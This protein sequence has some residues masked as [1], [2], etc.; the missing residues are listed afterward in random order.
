MDPTTPTNTA[1]D[2]SGLTP[3]LNEQQIRENINALQKG[4]LTNDKVQSYVDNYS[5]GL[6]GNYV[7]KSSNAGKD[8]QSGK[9]TGAF[10][11]ADTTS[12]SINGVD[13]LKMI[14][15]IVSSA[16]KPVKD[17][18]NTVSQYPEQIQGLIKES[19]GLGNAIQNFASASLDT[20]LKSL[21]NI[22]VGILEHI[23]TQFGGKE[24]S[25]GDLPGVARTI[26]RNLINDPVGMFLSM[27]GIKGSLEGGTEAI[28]TGDLSK[29]ME[30]GR[31]G[32]NKPMEL[33]TPAIPEAVKNIVGQTADKAGGIAND[34]ANSLE[35]I[36]LRLTPVQKVNLGSKL[37]DITDF[38]LKNDITG[39][40]E[41][42]YEKITELYNQKENTLQKFLN[43]DAKNVTVPKEQ[44]L[45]DLESLKG[46]YQDER[47]VLAIEKQID[48]LKNTIELKYPKDI[49][50]SKLNNLKRS[51]F[52]NAYN[53]AGDKVVDFVEH[54]MGDVLYS[55]VKDALKE[56][57]IGPEGKS[58]EDF[59]KEYGNIITS[60]KLLKIAQS[61]PEIGL[62]GKL[63][64]R[65]IG[66]LV[67][68]VFGGGPIGSAT[69]MIAGPTAAEA[70]AGTASRSTVA[71]TLKNI[72]ETIK[73]LN[74]EAPTA[75]PSGIGESPTLGNTKTLPD[76]TI[77]PPNPS[78]F[79]QGGI[80]QTNIVYHGTKAPIDSLKQ[81]DVLQYGKP[82]ALYGPGLY[83]TDNPEVAK[84]Y[85]ITKGHGEVG[86]VLSG[87]IKSNVKLLN[88]DENLN[89]E[90]LK[91][92]EHG[93]N[94]GN[95]SGIP[96]QLIGKN[97]QLVM[98]Q[99]MS[100][101][102]GMPTHEAVEIIDNLQGNLENLGYD[103]FKHIGGQ[104]TGGVPS[105]ISIL[106]DGGARSA[107]DKIK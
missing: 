50:V 1:P 35:K 39:T 4:G 93:I 36:N 89:P 31:E 106:W 83:L 73:G 18:V 52:D 79:K 101:L 67:G 92:I 3:T 87:E 66:A 65:A 90:V 86:K 82:N 51:T 63:T 60:K 88:L 78:S 62:V 61:R 71:S 13:A 19:G 48:G 42:R 53:N 85:S 104:I 20:G 98:K 14:P 102:D 99:F 64:S 94:T 15:N 34:M 33:P 6:D 32:F 5:K 45:T 77:K 103:G 49:P 2:T 11:P 47:D 17:I 75:K 70:I 10:M 56:K 38:N 80:P 24:L 76:A 41:A 12:K 27:Q 107:V 30:A 95:E 23:A 105:N 58:L 37:K 96:L 59:N 16:V 68:G 8:L 54:D 21:V 84:G 55:H 22:P 26:T 91:I 69:G 100:S 28:K 74:A 72:S 9:E 29:G 46:S 25:N 97:G 57:G 7:L 44:V 43:N 40:P 81:V